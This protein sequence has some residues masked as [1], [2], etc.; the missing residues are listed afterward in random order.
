[1][2][3]FALVGDFQS[4]PTS[5]H[6]LAYLWHLPLLH[7]SASLILG[8]WHHSVSGRFVIDHPLSGLFSFSSSS[9]NAFTIS[10][11]SFSHHPPSSLYLHGRIQ[12]SLESHSLTPSIS[13]GPTF[14]D[15]ALFHPDT[16]SHSTCSGHTRLPG[17]PSS[18]PQLLRHTTS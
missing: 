14:S 6:R 11:T 16:H 1:M 12:S 10:N 9:R 2:T 3:P 7:W 18:L 13:S 8:A 15:I 5:P 4:S 17:R